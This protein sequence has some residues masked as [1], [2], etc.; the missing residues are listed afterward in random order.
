VALVRKIVPKRIKIETRLAP[1]QLAVYADAVEFRQVFVNLSLNAADA[2]PQQG[3][4]LFETSKHDTFQPTTHVQGVPPRMPAVCLTVRDTGCGIPDRSLASI[5]DPFFT[6][7]EINKG[8]GLGL[9]NASLFVEKHQGAI[10][11]ESK[12]QEGTAFHLWLPQADFTETERGPKT[13]LSRHN[14]LLAGANGTA[15]NSMAQ[16]LRRNDFGVVVSTSSANAY[17]LLTSPDY[18]FS[19]VILQTTLGQSTLFQEMGRRNIPA[20]AILQIISRNPDE[21]ATSLIKRAD[22]T[23]PADTPENTML[24]RIK[25]LVKKPA[26]PS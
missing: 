19:A 18:Q 9:Y 26:T 12:V 16:L 13:I 7:K 24:T 20:K 23:L 1:G 22:L 6:T 15:L 25:E 2:M 5:F 3:S 21:I 14:L 4:L 8:S 17:E 11:V 10:S